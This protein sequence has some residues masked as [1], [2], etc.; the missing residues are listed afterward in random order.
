LRREGGD[1]LCLPRVRVPLRTA[2][3]CP[4]RDGGEAGGTP[5]VL[6][7][8]ARGETMT[9]HRGA[10]TPWAAW[11]ALVAL[12]GSLLQ[13]GCAGSRSEQRPEPGPASPAQPAP[14]TQAPPAA[15]PNAP[16][17]LPP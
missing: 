8:A 4:I 6:H 12:T 13:A 15:V 1:G 2:G 10:A 17:P 11:L 9:P 3:Q 14:T 7:A 5:G 16:V